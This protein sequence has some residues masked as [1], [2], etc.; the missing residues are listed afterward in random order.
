[1]IDEGKRS[2]SYG[3]GG[4]VIYQQFNDFQDI[5]AQIYIHS[6][7][8]SPTT[9]GV[10]NPNSLFRLETKGI[11]YEDKTTQALLFVEEDGWS[12]IIGSVM[13]DVSEILERDYYSAY[14]EKKMKYINLLKEHNIKNVN[15]LIAY[16][17]AWDLF[18]DAF[19]NDI[20]KKTLKTQIQLESNTTNTTSR[21]IY[22]TV[23]A[24]LDLEKDLYKSKGNFDDEESYKQ[25]KKDRLEGIKEGYYGNDMS[26][27]LYEKIFKHIKVYKEY[28]DN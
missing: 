2:R 27:R 4:D 20:N 25:A 22:Q 23:T 17:K 26:R 14:R 28:F 6:I 7:F 10:V 9:Q 5:S 24:M 12:K 18:K 16:Y 8:I 3:V 15:E 13:F 11:N 21:L 19:L 1:V